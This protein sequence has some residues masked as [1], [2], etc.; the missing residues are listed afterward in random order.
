MLTMSTK[1]KDMAKK[2]T[3]L[4]SISHN[5]D[6]NLITNDLKSDKKDFIILRNKEAVS[7]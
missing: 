7:G 2:L 5:T 4:A 6:K 1:L 3:S